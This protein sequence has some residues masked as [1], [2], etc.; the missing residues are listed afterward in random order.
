MAENYWV[1]KGRLVLYLKRS[2]QITNLTVLYVIVFAPFYSWSRKLFNIIEPKLNYSF[3][4]TFP[5]SK[6]KNSK[7][8][9]D[10]NSGVIYFKSDLWLN[11]SRLSNPDRMVGAPGSV[12]SA[13]ARWPIAVVR[14]PV[15]VFC[16]L[17]RVGQVVMVKN[18]Y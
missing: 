14:W 2:L 7:A 4:L 15:W 1:W 11:D 8:G 12:E 6:L 5:L 9:N 3:L 10:P 13:H 18:R 17:G 16:G